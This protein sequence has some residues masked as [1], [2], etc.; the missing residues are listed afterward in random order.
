MQRAF[1]PEISSDFVESP[2]MCS[3]FLFA[4]FHF[5]SFHFTSLGRSVYNNSTR[6][7]SSLVFGAA[8]LVRLCVLE[9]LVGAGAGSHFQIGRECAAETSRSVRVA[10]RVH[11]AEQQQPAAAGSL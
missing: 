9:E 5:I 11:T 4:S 2:E 1:G 10:E 3:P 6:L 7:N 8:P